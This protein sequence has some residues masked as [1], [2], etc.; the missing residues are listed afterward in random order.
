[1]SGESNHD[2]DG[3][4]DE[5]ARVS[6]TRQLS[7]SDAGGGA[8]QQARLRAA[9]RLLALVTNAPRARGLEATVKHCTTALQTLLPGCA[10]G[11]R[12]LRPNGTWVVHTMG[13]QEH[14]PQLA[15]SS[16]LFPN[17]TEE[18]VVQLD[19][20]LGA[21]L[22]M[23]A[24]SPGPCA[25][26]SAEAQ[27]LEAA[28]A[29]LRVALQGGYDLELVQRLRVDVEK[30]RARIIQGE[31]LA[32]LGQIVANVVHELNNPLTSIVAYAEYLAQ[33]SAAGA[34]VPP[35]DTERLG[36]IVE[37][38]ERA[39]S[40]ARDLMDYAKP[41]TEPPGPVSLHDVID[42]ALVFCEHE[43][44]ANQVEV[45]REFADSSLH[46]RGIAGHL[47]QV[48]VNLFTN[49]AQAMATSGGQL[50]VT[51]NRDAD[52]AQVQIADTGVG[53]DCESLK[54]IFEPYFTTREGR[55]GTGLGLAI[56]QDIVST[57][58]GSLRARSTP[59]QGTVF[60]LTLPLT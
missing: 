25:A 50:R 37:A 22:H 57:H 7:R 6:Q 26:E 1:M 55:H 5:L 48:F 52:S 23:A 58:G 12:V 4:A 14:P 32:S 41:A 60:T 30:L 46:V 8:D 19:Q 53:V 39:R 13:A 40:F 36:R 38:A 18:R 56:V 49:A 59:G 33:R 45:V 31:K 27:L 15:S 51:V 34:A 2:P 44:K 28:A 3:T 43:L 9:P 16:R 17:F 54:K 35:P 10:I 29:P 20:T 21:T 11:L 42:K 47:V 24:A